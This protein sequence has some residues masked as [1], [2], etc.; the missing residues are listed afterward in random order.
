[1]ITVYL[2]QHG[3]AKSKDEDPERPLTATGREETERIAEL[4]AH[5][6]LDIDAIWH[7]GK[8]RAEETAVIYGRALGLMGDV[9]EVDGLHPTDDVGA[10]ADRIV[11]ADKSVMLVGH[12]PF[13]P[14]MAGH[15]AAGDE[16]ESPVDFRYSGIVA[17]THKDGGWRGDWQLNPI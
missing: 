16:D 8:T 4:A 7:S 14:N 9:S 11:E 12:K 15:L 6:E 5:L 17:F 13:M 1:M 2:V 3:E 10:M